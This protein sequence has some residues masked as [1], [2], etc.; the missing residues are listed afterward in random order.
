MMKTSKDHTTVILM[1]IDGTHRYLNA[2]HSLTNK[3]VWD[4]VRDVLRHLEWNNSINEMFLA[5]GVQSLRYTAGEVLELAAK[6]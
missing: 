3:Q 5:C 6:E 4:F 1:M 2:T